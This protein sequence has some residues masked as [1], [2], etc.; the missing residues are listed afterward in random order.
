LFIT[1]LILLLVLIAAAVVIPMFLV[2]IP[3]M[4]KDNNT[5]SPSSVQADVTGTQASTLSSKSTAGCTSMTI[6]NMEGN[7]SVGSAI[8]R[9]ITLANTDYNLNL[10]ASTLVGLFNEAGLSCAAENALVTFDGTTQKRAESSSTLGVQRAEATSNG[11]VYDS[12]P[13]PSESSSSASPTASSSSSSTAADVDVD[14]ARAA[15]L[16]VLQT[17]SSLDETESVQKALQEGLSGGGVVESG[18]WK[19]DLGKKTVTGGT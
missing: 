14:F 1:L 16:Y 18:K 10:D 9:L 12:T 4:H 6:P 7:A 15:I 11:I 8:P 13:S 5:T 19:V 17:S 3:N 2:V